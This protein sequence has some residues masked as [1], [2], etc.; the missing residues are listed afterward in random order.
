MDWMLVLFGWT[1]VAIAGTQA[2]L[3][4]GYRQRVLPCW[5]R[6]S[7]GRSRAWRRPRRFASSSSRRSTGT[8]PRIRPAPP[9]L[10]CP[11]CWRG[12]DGPCPERV[13]AGAC[14]RPSPPPLS[15]CAPPAG[16]TTPC[17]TAATA[18]SWSATAA[19]P[20]CVPS[21]S[22]SGRRAWTPKVWDN[23]DAVFDPSDEDEA[24]RWRFN[25]KPLEKFDLA[26]GEA[27]FHGQ[28]TPFRH[29]AFF[30]EQAANWAWQDAARP[31]HQGP[32]AQGAE[33]VRLHRRGQPGL[34]RR[35]RGRHPCGRLQEVGRLRPR[36]RRLRRSGR[37]ADPLDR[38]GRPPLRGP[39]GAARFAIRRHHPGPAEVRPR[40]PTAR[41]G[42]CS[43][44]WPS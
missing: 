44:T 39:R 40:A 27:K 11:G 32:A 42:G 1:C 17:W 8:R 6:S 5:A 25:G 7:T 19:T 31:G 28:F 38:R 3:R 21:R 10:C 12:L 15:S 16:P 24:G 34:R 2:Q 4:A 41:S 23:A 33:P 20:S 35:R 18:R 43:R 26:W 36:E 13:L 30:P 29:L 9:T 37:Q 22:A 14:I